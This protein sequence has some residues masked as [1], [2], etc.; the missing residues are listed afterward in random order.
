M[1]CYLSPDYR[2]PHRTSGISISPAQLWPWQEASSISAPCW[3][4]QVA[5]A[6]PQRVGAE[7]TMGKDALRTRKVQRHG[8]KFLSRR[9]LCLISLLKKRLVSQF[10][11]NSAAQIKPP[12]PSLQ[13]SCFLWEFRVCLRTKSPTVIL[14]NADRNYSSP[15]AFLISPVTMSKGK[16]PHSVIFPHHLQQINNVYNKRT[17]FSFRRGD[18]PAYV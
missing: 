11:C 5:S 6:Q 8:N 4:H 14:K 3:P 18:K 15:L 17:Q 13:N 16:N 12:V 7:R 1:H 9:G 10:S 2:G